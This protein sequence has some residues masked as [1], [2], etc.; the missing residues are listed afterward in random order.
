[1]KR[2][3]GDGM[4]AVVAMVSSVSSVGPLS[5]LGF[6]CTGSAGMCMS[7]RACVYAH[8]RVHVYVRA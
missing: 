5:S 4:A 7:M 2:T 3:V 1:M 8:V 6:P